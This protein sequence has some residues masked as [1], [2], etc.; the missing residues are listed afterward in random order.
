MKGSIASAHRRFA[1]TLLCTALASFAAVSAAEP[2]YLTTGRGEHVKT[3]TGLCVHTSDWK[4]GLTNAECDPAAAVA[5]VVVPEPVEEPKAT[6][7]PAP[8]PAP[9]VVAVPPTIEKISISSEVLF[10]FDSATLRDEGKRE[11]DALIK[12]IADASLEGIAA[13]GYAD[14]IG[15]EKYNQALSEKRAAAVK[16]YLSE[17]GAA[18][19]VV[20]AEGRGESAPVTGAQCDGLGR[21][22]ASNKKLVQCLQPD[23]RV[24]IEVF[25]TRTATTEQSPS[26]GKTL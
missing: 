4:P 9:V 17:N 5:T 26:A 10:A 13:I 16:Q 7:A 12:R 2:G 14:R 15:S 3:I 6:P 25:G 18:T 20:R 23:R 11:L 21:E 19:T 1:G 22:R 8:E 24:E